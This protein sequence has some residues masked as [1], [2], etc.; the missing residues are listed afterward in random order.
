MTPRPAGSLEGGL[1]VRWR[2]LAGHGIEHLTLRATADGLRA[3][4]VVIGEHEGSP[5]GATY[6]ILLDAGFAV[7]AFTILATDGRAL[8]LARK[9]G[10]WFDETGR[11]LPEFDNSPDIDLT[12]TPFTN[13]LPIRRESWEIGQRREFDMLFVPFDSFEPIVH[14]QVYTCLAPRLFR[15][16]VADGSFTADLPLDEHGL[17]LDYPHLF[18]RC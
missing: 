6:S 14:G 4:S 18:E 12:G 5:Y 16:E 7:Q 2:P 13:T 11:H 15:F 3:D 8:A 9:D 17:V 1:D 10:R